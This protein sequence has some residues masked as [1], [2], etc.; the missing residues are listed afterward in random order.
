MPRT[1]ALNATRRANAARVLGILAAACCGAA[2]LGPAVSQEPPRRILSSWRVWT[3]P[4]PLAVIDAAAVRHGDQI[5]LL[6]GLDRKFEA[7]AA[8]QRHTSRGGWDPIGDRL[9]VPRAGASL[10]GLP[11]GRVVIL[12][13]Y[14]GSPSEPRWHDSGE[15][16]DLEIAG[17]SVELPPFGES[18]EG[19]SAT[20]LADGRI[21]VVSGRSA[22]VLDPTAPIEHAWGPALDLPEA[23]R[24]HAAARLADGRVLIACGAAPSTE[25]PPSIRVL[26]ISDDPD[27]A[28][29]LAAGPAEA[30]A[31]LPAELRDISAA[32]DPR[33]GDLLLAGGLDPRSGDTVSGTWWV[34]RERFALRPGLPIP[35]QHGASRIHLEPLEEGIA[36]IGGE[37]RTPTARGA[38]DL[39]LFVS[40]GAA[41]DRRSTLAPMP[42][43]ATRRMR[44]QGARFEWIGGY[45]FRGP[46]EAEALGLPAG[47]HFDH[48][49]YRL[50]SVPPS[51]G[52]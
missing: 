14:A 8:I 42:V 44:I 37:W 39:S 46:A 36:V 31:D 27:A 10:V 9:A 16:I 18:L 4:M 15:S 30:G 21:L 43:S 41:L 11:D 7:T 23:R 12:G 17:S 32:L 25:S 19:H 2:A 34:D 29:R 49:R 48:R 52:D 47:V 45:R 33:R 35:I 6:G 5:H 51:R 1:A 28:P 38:A 50:S 13:G 24:G 3:D 26:E 40:G 20:P 22:R